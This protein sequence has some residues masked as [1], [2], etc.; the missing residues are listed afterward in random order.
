MINYLTSFPAC[1]LA[2]GQ[3]TNFISIEKLDEPYRRA[4]GKR[5]SYLMDYRWLS[6]E[7]ASPDDEAYVCVQG[8]EH[9]YWS[10]KELQELGIKTN[11]KAPVSESYNVFDNVT[12][13]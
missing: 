9:S 12:I 11:K 10:A 7:C 1:L 6:C 2:Q 3:G 4:D 8:N 13:M 5:V